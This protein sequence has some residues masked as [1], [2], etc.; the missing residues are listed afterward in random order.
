M[1]PAK[2]RAPNA[3]QRSRAVKV[4]TPQAD[5][6]DFP[7]EWAGETYTAHMPKDLVWMQMFAALEPG[8][9]ITEKAGAHTLF[10]QA[11]LVPTDRDRIKSRLIDRSDPALG[12]DLLECM[13][14]LIKRWEPHLK[15]IFGSDD[16]ADR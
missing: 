7:F 5:D 10:I 15:N 13:K 3:N 9:T 1:P 6:T 11:C 2:R 16:A 14:E 8:A 12:M 4:S